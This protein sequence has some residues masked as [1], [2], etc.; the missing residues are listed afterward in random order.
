MA[1]HLHQQ[2]IYTVKGNA[3]AGYGIYATQNIAPNYIIF[4][5]EG[6]WQRI[7]TK[8]YVQQH[9]S[10]EEQENFRRYAY[11]VSD[12]VFIL[13]D[14]Q[15]ENWAPQNHSCEPNTAYKG[16]NVYAIRPI[17]K[18]EELTLD[19][20]SFLSTDMEPFMCQCQSENC[21]GLVTGTANNTITERAKRTS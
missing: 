12:E 10:A 19:Y 20:T 3:I 8:A 5:G 9:W 7:V 21:K 4:L 11:P 17:A 1:R 6:R 14:D 16:L 2:K 13:W 15:P 18:G